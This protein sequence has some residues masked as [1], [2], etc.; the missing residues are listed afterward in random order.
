VYAG[1]G[2]NY[3]IVNNYYK[4]G[5]VTS[6]WVKARIVNPYKKDTTIPFGKFF[7]EGNFVD[8]AADVTSDNWKGVHMNEGTPDV[9]QKAKL[10]TP[11]PYEPIPV[12]SAEQAYQS[13][14]ASAGAIFPAR[15]TLDVRIIQDVVNRT[16]RLIDVQGGYPHG[17][18]YEKTM[19]AWPFLNPGTASM[20]TDQDGMPDD[21][22]KKNRLDPVNPDDASGY[23][24]SKGY[25][26]IEVYLNS[27]VK[28]K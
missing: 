20:D 28:G 2:G 9:K 15:D 23:S 22:E 12:Q 13:V 18:E 17:T 7:V 11:V 16:G 5:P 24:I 14:L 25:T 19:N 1:E 6:K 4:Y 21:W 10:V 3:N 26:N 27:L 8:G